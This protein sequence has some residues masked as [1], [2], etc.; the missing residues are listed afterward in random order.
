MKL[1]IASDHAGYALKEKIKKWLDSKRISYLDFGTH[2]SKASVDYP[3]YAKK[4]AKEVLKSKQNL[5]ILICGT[6][7]GMAIAANKIKGI[8][9]VSAYDLYTAKMSRTHNNANVLT[10][11]GRFFPYKKSIQILNAFLSVSFSN[12]PRHKKRIKK[13]EK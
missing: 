6:G 11:R 8:R 13:I 1:I 2:S 12:E 5:G 3:D 9:A 7:I 10:L 4:A